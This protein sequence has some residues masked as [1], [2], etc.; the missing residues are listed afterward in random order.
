MTGK[1]FYIEKI[2]YFSFYE[3]KKKLQYCSLFFFFE[4]LEKI[5][6]SIGLKIYKLGKGKRK[7]INI[8]PYILNKSAQYKK[9]IYWLAKAI[10]L[11]KENTLCLKICLEF[12]DINFNNS[13]NSLKKKKEYYKYVI[14]F[15]AI[16]KFKW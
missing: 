12:Y 16:K 15:K 5:K 13:G 6:P 11:R 7:K 9:S 1:K 4:A 10:K 2:I 8:F 14:M 3:L